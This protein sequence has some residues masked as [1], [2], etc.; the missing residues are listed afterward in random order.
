MV[1][2]TSEDMTCPKYIT[3]I[4]HVPDWDAH[5]EK[6]SYSEE[7]KRI[8]LLAQQKMKRWFDDNALTDWKRETDKKG[9]TYD[10][11]QSSTGFS[12]FRAAMKMPFSPMDIFLTLCD[13]SRRQKYDG[14][15]DVTENIKK[16]AANTYACYQRSNRVAMV[17]SSR[18]F[19]IVTYM[20]QV[21]NS[22]FDPILNAA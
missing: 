10:S 4:T 19:M 18:D 3:E 13:G 11:R 17:I 9:F 16:L 12:M 5:F 14:N 7:Q 2:A 6:H 22:H 8:V 20:H 21:S 1:D 15:I